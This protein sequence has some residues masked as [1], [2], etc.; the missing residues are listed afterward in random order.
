MASNQPRWG[1]RE[2]GWRLLGPP[3]SRVGTTLFD[4][5]AGGLHHLPADGPALLV[6][7]HV[8]HL[9]PLVLVTAVL[10]GRGRR[11]RF[12][13]LADLFNDRFIGWWLRR[14][15]AIPV[16]RGRGV[17]PV[18]EAATDALDHGEVVVV[19][20]EGR[21]PR[22]QPV[23]ARPGAGAIALATDAPTIPVGLWGMQADL[24]GPRLRRPAAVELGAPVH[25]R[26]FGMD[27][28]AAVSAAL[29]AVVRAD[30][31]PRARIRCGFPPDHPD[32]D[33]SRQVPAT[34][35]TWR[36]TVA[37]GSRFLR[38]G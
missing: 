12:L 38:G 29:L 16:R 31:L 13:A 5:R 20:P 4:V 19:Y 7:N 30:L 15:G 24:P 10:K 3:V 26:R 27:D 9:D 18:V 6:A 1:R 2:V 22:G 17:A 36:T 23:A 8:G 37:I 11:V 34:G 33:P 32:I 28:P 21:L 35:S 25:G 14:A